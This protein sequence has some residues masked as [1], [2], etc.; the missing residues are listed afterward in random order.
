MIMKFDFKKSQE[1]QKCDICHQ[2][3]FPQEAEIR[4][5]ADN[6]VSVT[7]EKMCIDCFISFMEFAYK[8]EKEIIE[9]AK[10][11]RE[12]QINTRREKVDI[13]KT[14]LTENKEKTKCFYC[15]DEID[16]KE[17][18][19]IM[20]TI[21]NGVPCSYNICMS[22]FIKILNRINKN[23]NIIEKDVLDKIEILSVKQNLEKRKAKI[24]D[25]I[26]NLRR[27]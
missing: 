17:T 21:E 19:M 22:C 11:L 10:G 23:G 15:G 2:D 1:K 26:I 16:V 4:L 25:E 6:E 20:E 3:I 8:D 9:T 18:V 12:H 14:Y 13:K 24:L 5:I 27:N 7:K